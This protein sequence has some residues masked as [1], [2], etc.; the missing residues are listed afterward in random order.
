MMINRIKQ[1][2]KDIVNGKYEFT[3]FYV[4]LAV[5]AGY[6][7]LHDLLGGTF[8]SHCHWDSYT[9][10]AMA[11]RE[12]RVSLGQ[13]YTYL[14]L[15]IYNNDW[16]VSFPPTPSVF[17]LPWTFFFGYDTPNNII[18]IIYVM[19]TIFFAYLIGR[20]FKMSEAHS[21]FYAC[22]L[23]LGS[24]MLWMSTMGGVWFQAQLLSMMLCVIGIFAMLK[25]QREIAYIAIALAVGC[26]P[27]SIVYFLVLIVWFYIKDK[28][29]YQKGFIKT[30]LYQLEGVIC[31]AIIGMGYMAYN[32]AR[33]NNP[34]EFGHNYLPEFLEAPDGQFSP[35]YF[36]ENIKNIFTRGIEFEENGKLIFTSF[37]GFLFYVAN[38]MFL[39]LFGYTIVKIVEKVR[40][41]L[42]Y[43]RLFINKED[44]VMLVI[45]ICL[46]LNMCMLC[47]HKTFGGWQFGCR[48][49]CDLLPFTMLF[50]F[51][52]K[53]KNVKLTGPE[54]TIGLFAIFFNLY[55]T[56]FMNMS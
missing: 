41:I 54:I 22:F 44:G 2:G 11:W 10:Q 37:D 3:I 16:Y 56:M 49:M 27:F 46:V 53:K 26:R 29:K 25:M 8:F 23:V 32:Y 24:N 17:M 36:M 13:N 1:W 5:L 19:I 30:L 14:E 42:K 51:L 31:A 20:H 7:L 50:I 47:V 40:E 39:I 4:L 38:P 28:E 33:F 48:Y 35:V 15:A 21:S 6:Y 18:M 12:G 52:A 43:K 55:G 45:F 34:F 9:L